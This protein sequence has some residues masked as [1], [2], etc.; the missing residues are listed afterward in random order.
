MTTEIRVFGPPGTGKTTY[1]INKILPEAIA[2]HGLDKVLITSFT[3]A[4]AKEI[5]QRLT[6]KYKI[7]VEIE[8]WDEPLDTEPDCVRATTLHAACFAVLGRPKLATGVV[9]K[10]NDEY[11]QWVITSEGGTTGESDS[12]GGQDM[13]SQCNIYRNKMIDPLTVP[14]LKPFY[15]KW[16][17]FKTNNHVMDFTDLI[18]QSIKTIFFAPWGA[19]CLICDEAQDLTKLEFALIRSWGLQMQELYLAGDDDQCIYSFK[20]SDPYNF[21]TDDISCQIEKVILSKSY[22]LPKQIWEFSNQFVKQIKPRQPKEFTH[23]GE[24]GELIRAG[25]SI[26]HVDELV[27][28]A[29]K[30]S[31][32]GSVLILTSCSYMLKPV[33]DVMRGLGIQF[34]NPYRIADKSWNPCATKAFELLQDIKNGEGFNVWGEFLDKRTYRKG[35][36]KKQ[37]EADLDLLYDKFQSAEGIDL[38]I[39]SYE[40]MIKYLKDETLDEIDTVWGDTKSRVEWFYNN[41]TL[42]ERKRFDYAI[43]TEQ[44]KIQAKNP[45]MPSTIHAIKGGEADCVFISPDISPVGFKQFLSDQ[46]PVLRLFYVGITRARHK[47]VIL[48]PSTRYHVSL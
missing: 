2:K 46:N 44:C 41:I 29:L 4:A 37:L 39:E 38:R 8:P 35:M 27:D 30:E 26:A 28:I 24:S 32:T 18:E 19:T 16:Q 14:I 15:T 11:P 6:A 3:K 9:K 23:S 25:F 12:Y 36:T 47:L 7:S 10:W 43:K 42:G 34:G 48:N 21:I 31:M 13:L 45:I 17:E 33:C 20:G 22:R 40:L 5:A 1:I